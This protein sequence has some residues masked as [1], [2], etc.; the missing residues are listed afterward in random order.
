MKSPVAHVVEAHRPSDEPPPAA[1]VA[2]PPPDA[3][4]VAAAAGAAVVALLPES[5][6]SSPTPPP[7]STAP[8]ARRRA[9]ATD[10]FVDSTPPAH[11][12]YLGSARPPLTARIVGIAAHATAGSRKAACERWMS[13]RV[14]RRTN[15]PGRHPRAREMPR[16]P[17]RCPRQR[18]VGGQGA[19]ARG[20]GE[21]RDEGRH[22]A[23]R[24]RR[25]PRRPRPARLDGRVDASRGRARPRRA[26]VHDEHALRGAERTDDSTTAAAPATSSTRCGTAS[27]LVRHQ[28]AGKSSV[29]QPQ[30]GHAER[31]RG[32]RASSGGP[33]TP[34]PRRTRSPPGG[35]PAR[36]G[37]S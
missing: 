12:A 3:A 4:V 30:D 11:A 37:R 19:S 29:R 24:S 1:V 17:A 16:R 6:S 7:R 9:N 10:R 22:G 21:R 34:W 5:S 18:Q 8:R 31:S 33:G 13:R 28:K 25:R 27:P 32:P 2:V 15:P 14:V 20:A 35:G 23:A 36:S 26:R